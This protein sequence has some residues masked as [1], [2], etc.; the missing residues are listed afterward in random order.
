M[1]EQLT[2]VIA[3]A[4]LQPAQLADTL[5]LRCAGLAGEERVVRSKLSP[6]ELFNLI[7]DRCPQS[8]WVPS[9]ATQGRNII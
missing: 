7:S 3:V 8:L 1:T 2:S 4:S 5:P 6:L 9:L